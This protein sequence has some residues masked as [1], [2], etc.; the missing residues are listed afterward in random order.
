MHTIDPSDPRTRP[1]DQAVREAGGADQKPAGAGGRRREAADGPPA[2]RSNQRNS[3]D[4]EKEEGTESKGIRSLDFEEAQQPPVLS[5]F[6]DGES[7]GQ[8]ADEEDGREDRKEE[9]EDGE[10]VGSASSASQHPLAAFGLPPNLSIA[11]CSMLAAGRSGGAEAAGPSNPAAFL[12]A[13]GGGLRLPSSPFGGPNGIVLAA[14]PTSAPASAFFL[15]SP[16]SSPPAN[17]ATYMQSFAAMSA[18]VNAAMAAKSSSDQN[19]S[20]DATTISVNS[21]PGAFRSESRSPSSR[22]TSPSQSG[23]SQLSCAVCGDVSSGKHYGILAC[24]GCSGFFKRSVRRRLIYRC[25]AGTGTCVVDKAHRNQCQH[26]RLRK[27]L[28]RGMNKDA[29]QNERQPRN[30]GDHPNARSGRLVPAGRPAAHFAR[31][32]ARRNFSLPRRSPSSSSRTASNRAGGWRRE[33]ARL[34]IDSPLPL[35]SAANAEA[36]ARMLF[37]AVKWTKTLPSFAALC[38]PDQLTLLMNSWA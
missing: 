38:A 9:E 25:Q 23:N 15:N 28:T 31:T 27:C 11:L 26:C 3:I 13:A 35:Q 36:S 5:A 16:A 1:V 20:F 29:V 7:N 30:T 4:E 14:T 24:N 10:S 19:N 2:K 6:A 34:P 8:K 21:F 12:Q 22:S 32:T 17:A 33:E 18:A 37:M